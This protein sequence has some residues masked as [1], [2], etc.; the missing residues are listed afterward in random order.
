MGIVREK[1]TYADIAP[2]LERKVRKRIRADRNLPSEWKGNELLT[3]AH[4]MY[5]E[6]RDTA[7]LNQRWAMEHDI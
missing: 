7:T 2:Q 4:G 6:E 3:K 1:E 5:W